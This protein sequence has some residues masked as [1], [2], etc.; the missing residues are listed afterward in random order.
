MKRLKD[1]EITKEF[2]SRIVAFSIAESG[3]MGNPGSIIFFTDEKELYETNYHYE[4]EVQECFKIFDIFH[5][6]TNNLLGKGNRVPEGWRYTY[7]GAGNHLF[8]MEW[9]EALFYSVLDKDMPE[10]EIYLCWIDTVMQILAKLENKKDYQ[11]VRNTQRTDFDIVPYDAKR[12]EIGGNH[13]IRES[14][15]VKW[16]SGYENKEKIVAIGINPSTAQDGESDTTMTK[17]CRFLDLY[18]FNNV[19][20]LNLFESVSPDQSKINESTRTDFSKKSAE[21]ENAD[22][23]LLVWG[24]DG[25]KAEKEDAMSALMKYADKLYCIRNTKG[26]FPAHPSRMPYQSEL[27]PLVSGNDFI[28]CGMSPKSK[29]KRHETCEHVMMECDL[30]IFQEEQYIMSL[31]AGTSS[32]YQFSKIVDKGIEGADR[33]EYSFNCNRDVYIKGNR[34]LQFIKQEYEKYYDEAKKK[35]NDDDTDYKIVC[36]DMS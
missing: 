14:L 23:I 10:S 32:V 35:I 26:K 2:I 18:G 7:L 16:E 1:V 12:K 20:M 34:L 11:K 15:S 13:S 9:L 19:T 25:H 30:N 24:I 27:I 3:A 6:C 4:G 17:L 22:I 33:V 36:Y 8:M 5:Q 21:L 29:E 28:A 31:G